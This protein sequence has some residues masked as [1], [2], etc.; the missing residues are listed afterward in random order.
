MLYSVAGQFAN[1]ATNGSDMTAKIFF[2]DTHSFF[3]FVE[4][5]R[6][7]AHEVSPQTYKLYAY[8]GDSRVLTTTVHNYGGDSYHFGQN[9]TNE[10]C[11]GGVIEFAVVGTT[12]SYY[13][14]VDATGCAYALRNYLG[15]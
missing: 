13:F 11:K 2:D 8:R 5:N 7:N 15:K 1:T 12:S 6:H 4:Y 9:V 3:R 10:L 14:T